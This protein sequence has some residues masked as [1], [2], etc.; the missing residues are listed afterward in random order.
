[1]SGPFNLADDAKRAL[2]EA[3]NFCWRANVGI[4][5]AEHLLAG[6]LVQMAKDG[7]GGYPLER[8]E[9]ALAPLHPPGMTE[10]GNTV[11]FGSAAR[12]AMTAAVR[13]ARSAGITRLDAR[14]LALGVVRS[15]EVHPM[16]YG[17]LG[18]GRD[19]LISELST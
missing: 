14:G 16:F 13:D 15:G 19:A 3:E 10:L 4:V 8:L 9:A 1:M 6:C 18:V 2:R 12:D 11:M 17:T 5:S 7:Q